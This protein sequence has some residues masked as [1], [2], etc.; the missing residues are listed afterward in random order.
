MA[1]KKSIW[2]ELFGKENG[3]FI[4][5]LVDPESL[6][7]MERCYMM[8]NIYRDYCFYKDQKYDTYVIQLYE[9]TLSYLV[10]EYGH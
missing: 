5:E 7:G 4:S 3:L 8:D 1:T 6:S 2:E 10:K 9:D